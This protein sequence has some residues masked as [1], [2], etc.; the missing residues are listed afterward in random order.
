MESLA[1][2]SRPEIERSVVALLSEFLAPLKNA[3]RATVEAKKRPI[4]S[5]RTS[6]KYLTGN[7]I[8]PADFPPLEAL[9]TLVRKHDL[10]PEKK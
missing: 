6:V 10:D 4:L 8:V 2:E 7:Q 9:E 1:Y 5:L 3:G